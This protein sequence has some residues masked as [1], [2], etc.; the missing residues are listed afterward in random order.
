VQ[1]QGLRTFGGLMKL[2]SLILT[3]LVSTSAFAES[4]DLYACLEQNDSTIGREE[5][6]YEEFKNKDRHLYDLLKHQPKA[7]SLILKFAKARESI[8]TK[9]VADMEGGTGQGFAKF[10]CMTRLTQER[11]QQVQD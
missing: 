7:L 8:C 1:N 2:F 4:S 11:I 6:Q 3:V 5:C 9:E 10:E